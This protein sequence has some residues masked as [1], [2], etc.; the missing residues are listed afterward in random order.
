LNITINSNNKI[1]ISTFQ[2]EMNLHLYNPP[3]SAHPPSCLKGLITGELFRYKKQN[4]NEDFMKITTSFLERMAA[5][6]HKIENLTPLFHEAAATIDKKLF[7]SYLKNTE[8]S[9]ENSNSNQK[10]LYFHWKYHLHGITNSIIRHHYNKYLKNHL[11]IFNKMT[12]AILRPANLRDKLTRTALQLP[13]G[14]T[15]SSRLTAKHKQNQS[16]NN[17]TVTM[18]PTSV[19]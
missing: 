13:T 16:S 7:T 12:L 2:K 1:E 4:N 6:G 10:S 17:Q 8:P 18:L 19:G 14:D 9:S 3:S 11:Q 5:R 15:I